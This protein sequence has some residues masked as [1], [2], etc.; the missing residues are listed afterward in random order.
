MFLYDRKYFNSIFLILLITGEVEA[1][2]NPKAWVNNMNNNNCVRADG[3]C[4]QCD[5]WDEELEVCKQ[6][7]D[8]GGTRH[9]YISNSDADPGL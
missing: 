8:V 4:E 1:K 5:A 6:N 9:G 2:I 3:D 7:E